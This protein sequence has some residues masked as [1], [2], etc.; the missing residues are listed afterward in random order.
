MKTRITV[1][2][3]IQ[4]DFILLLLKKVDVCGAGAAFG[5]AT[6]KIPLNL[7]LVMLL[8]EKWNK[9]IWYEAENWRL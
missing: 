9:N 4:P 6:F 2:R 3:L 8:V 5:L 1:W 7:C